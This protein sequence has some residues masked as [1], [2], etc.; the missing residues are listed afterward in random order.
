[1]LPN[2]GS[3]LTFQGLYYA[4]QAEYSSFLRHQ[5]I[6]PTDFDL[7]VKGSEFLANHMSQHYIDFPYKNKSNLYYLT[8]PYFEGERYR[9]KG[10]VVLLSVGSPKAGNV[11]VDLV[12]Y[13]K[14]GRKKNPLYEFILESD[15]SQRLYDHKMLWQRS[16]GIFGTR[17][18]I[19][20]YLTS[21]QARFSTM[22]NQF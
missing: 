12:F 20:E 7:L 1:M 11:N 4:Y 14:E 6:P 2:P 18:E 8:V 13:L 22:I 19:S 3:S 9:R 10:G 21:N 17:L 16:G 15:N 5:R